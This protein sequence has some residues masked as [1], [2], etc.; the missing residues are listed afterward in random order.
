MSTNYKRIF[1]CAPSNRNHFWANLLLE[2]SVCLAD[3]VDRLLET[4]ELHEQGVQ[5][6]VLLVVHARAEILL[7]TITIFRDLGV[8]REVG[9]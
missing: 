9:S 4:G 2:V 3:L 7:R 8:Y 6:H 1:L 5:R